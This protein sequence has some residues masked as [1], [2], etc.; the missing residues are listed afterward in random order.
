M[1]QGIKKDGLEIYDNQ[2][3][4]RGVISAQKIKITHEDNPIVQM[5][6]SVMKIENT[7]AELNKPAQPENKRWVFNSLGNPFFYDEI[8]EKVFT[9]FR[10]NGLTFFQAQTALELLANDLK[11]MHV[12]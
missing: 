6:E 10:E 1:E 8:Q 5:A 2:D 7:L 3:R 9:L 4:V 11:D 12:S